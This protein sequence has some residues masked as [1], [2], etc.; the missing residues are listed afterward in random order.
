MENPNLDDLL[1]YLEYVGQRYPR[2]DIP[3]II[4]I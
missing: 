4:T 2:I 1:K 3:T